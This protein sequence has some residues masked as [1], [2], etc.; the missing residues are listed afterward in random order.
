MKPSNIVF[1]STPAHGHIN[2]T[3]PLVS[4][5]VLRGYRVIYYA[6]DEFRQKIEQ[7]GAIF[8]SYQNVS[9]SELIVKNL[10]TLYKT[11]LKA[12]SLIVDQLIDEISLD[13]P[14]L[15]IHDSLSYWGKIVSSLL[16]IPTVSSISTFAF[17]SND[18]NP[19]NYLSFIGHMGLGGLISLVVG[20]RIKKKLKVKYS[21]I[22][23][24]TSLFDFITGNSFMDV[25]NSSGRKNL[26]YTTKEFQKSAHQYS[27]D[28]YTFIGPMISERLN[29]PDQEDYSGLRKPVIY[30]SFGTIWND[31]LP[32]DLM[33]SSLKKLGGTIVFST[34]V[35][36]DV[37]LAGVISKQHVNQLAVLKNSDLF[38]THGGMNSINEA[39][40]FGVPMCVFPFQAEQEENCKQVVNLKCGLRIRKLTEKELCRSVKKVLTDDIYKKGC[41]RISKSFNEAGG[42]R[43]AI[44]EIESFGNLTSAST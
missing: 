4:A 2:P 25:M 22:I 40:F 3:L 20:H 16:G 6:T 14:A 13:N 31:Q 19:R 28:Q 43:L 12:S 7:H 36:T 24:K 18:V 23:K 34:A 41:K 42:V 10:A 32:V 29:D 33:I 8:R 27:P 38:I 30:V 26:V 35:L 21:G 1:L 15:I 9:P 17:S 37:S 39:L 44:A 5:L 11:I